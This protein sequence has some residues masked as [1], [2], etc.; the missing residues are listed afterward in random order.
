MVRSILICHAGARLNRYALPGWLDSFTD[1]AAVIVIRET[2]D[3]KRRRIRYQLKRDG[4][5]K[6]IDVMLMK[7]YYSASSLRSQDAKK[8]SQ[9]IARIQAAF[10]PP[11]QVQEFYT[12]NPNNK[13]TREFVSALSPDL[14]IVRCK[15]LLKPSL[16]DLPK[17]GSYVM[18]PGICPEYR[19]SHGCFWALLNR[20]L[21]NVGCTLLRIDKGIDTGPIYGF[22]RCD[23]DEVSDTHIDIQTRSVVDNLEPIKHKL[24]EITQNKAPVIDVRGRRS[25][26]WGQPGLTDFLRWK[27]LAKRH[28]RR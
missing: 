7:L 24:L 26:V 25:A 28:A 16:F 4:F 23:F 5:L 14:A 11:D 27:R 6:L 21:E 8:E 9:R 17:L 18:H 10:P 1:L 20:D 3:Q 2:R 19:N 15:L 12:T 13:A 22:Y